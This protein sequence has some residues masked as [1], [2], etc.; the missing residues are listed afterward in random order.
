MNGEKKVIEGILPVT[1]TKAVYIDGTNKTL[2]EAINNG[3]FGGSSAGTPVSNFIVDAF[4]LVNDVI[5][6]I[7]DTTKDITVKLNKKLTLNRIMVVSWSNGTST[8]ETFQDG[9]VIPN[10]TALYWDSVNGF[11]TEPFSSGIKT[12]YNKILV[13]LNHYGRITGGILEPIWSKYNKYTH[14]A[15]FEVERYI[16]MEEIKPLVKKTLHSMIVVGDEL[17]TLEC[18][19]EGNFNGNCEVYSLPDLTH[20]STFYQNIKPPKADGSVINLRLVCADYNGT[21]DCLL[22]GS[23]T[24]DGSDSNNMEAYIL[25]NASNLKTYTSNEDPITLDNVSNTVIDFHKDGL[26][27]EE[28]ITAKLVWSELEDIIY[29]THNNLQFC[30]KIQL[31]VGTNKLEYGTYNYD[32]SKRY[33]GTFRIIQTFAQA[34]PEIGNKDIQYYN[35]YLYYPVKYTEGGYRIYKTCLKHD[36]TMNHEMLIYDPIKN[37]GTHAINGSPEG[38]VIYKGQVIAAHATPGIFYKFNANI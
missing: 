22:L 16:N 24:A 27:G 17:W 3:E 32:E 21:N 8:Q 29:L 28:A 23:G 15:I 4:M 9:T 20:K 31:G 25:Y 2:H 1:T 10:N 33:N 37:N 13:G 36:G 14:Q 26:F 11:S 12:G 5:F 18:F 34:Y 38:I 30:H 6:T 19:E 7:N 35:G